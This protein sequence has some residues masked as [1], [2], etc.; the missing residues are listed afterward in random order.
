MKK[1]QDI[2]LLLI[3][4][5]IEL[6][7]YIPWKFKDIK[8]PC[9]EVQLAAVNEDGHNIKHIKNPCYEVQLAAIQY[10]TNVLSIKWY[11]DSINPYITYPDLLELIEIKLLCQ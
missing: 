2:N 7:K 5:Q 1:E 10:H 4:S 3:E 9:L 11:F 8:N 6:I